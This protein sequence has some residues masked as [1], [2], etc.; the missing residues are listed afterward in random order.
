[1]LTQKKLDNYVIALNYASIG[2]KDAALEH[3]E[4]SFEEGQGCLPWMNSEPVFEFLRDD[5]RFIE[6][7]KKMGLEDY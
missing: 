6:L 2:E 4:K 1:M 7:L 5:P 3:L